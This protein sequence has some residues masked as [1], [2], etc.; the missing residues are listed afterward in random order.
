MFKHR[1]VSPSAVNLKQVFG[2]IVRAKTSLFVVVFT[3][4]VLASL[5]PLLLPG[6]V[7][8]GDGSFGPNIPIADVFF[9][10]EVPVLGGI[11]P[12]L[13]PFSIFSSLLPVWMVQ[14]AVLF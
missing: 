8:A 14:K 13:L 1:N 4:L 2:S 3:P 12:A 7:L 6:Y 5:G 9:G 10:F 11:W